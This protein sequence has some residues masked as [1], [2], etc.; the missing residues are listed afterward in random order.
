MIN[1]KYI[2]KPIK[3]IIMKKLILALTV[4]F[5]IVCSSSFSQNAATILLG[6]D[7]NI[8]A[9]KDQSISTTISIIDKSGKQSVREMTLIQKGSDKR[10][11]KFLSPADQKGI[12]F[13]S[14]PGDNLT[15]YLPAFGK[16]RKIASSVK[17]TKFAGTDYS[18][19]DME[20]KKYSDK[21][22]PK[23]IK[24]EGGNN[25]LELTPKAGTVTDY[26]KLVMYARTADN[27]PVKIEHYDK[28]GKLYKIMN[29]SNI[30]KVGK[31]QI[32]KETVLADLR[33]GSKTKMVI[34]L[35]KFDTGLT[36]NNFTE[37]ELMK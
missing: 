23:F 30:Q 2:E 10:L 33:T 19:E 34:T 5:T 16:T 28:G 26:S 6:I 36:D 37:R 11:V 9:A 27:Y 4:M 3:I 12:G 32:A 21:W 25:V 29:A 14:L 35:V 1:K 31:Y 7:N 17:N 15:L 20:A 18:Y 22:N 24:T 13:L 8:N